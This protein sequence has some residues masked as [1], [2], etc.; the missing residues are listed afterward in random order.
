MGHLQTSI[1]KLIDSNVG[2][3]SR[4]VISSNPQTLPPPPPPAAPLQAESE[5]SYSQ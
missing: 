4:P 2:S 1:T 3:G 5:M